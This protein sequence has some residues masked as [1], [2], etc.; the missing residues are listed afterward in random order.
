MNATTKKL[1]IS[2]LV[3]GL[4]G[5]AYAQAGGSMGAGGNGSSGAGSAAGGKGGATGMG[6]AADST[7]G[8][9]AKSGMSNDATNGMGQDKGTVQR[10]V[11][12]NGDMNSGGMK[13]NGTGTHKAY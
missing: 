6:G 3:L 2:A 5:G 7:T 11:P 13:S 1:V 8:T 12:N 4:S 9:G 10:S